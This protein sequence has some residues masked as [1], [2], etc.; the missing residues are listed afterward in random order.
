MGNYLHRFSTDTEFNAAYSGSEYHAPWASYTEES[1]RV[2]YNKSKYYEP[3][4]IIFE[5]S[6]TFYFESPGSEIV[7]LVIYKLNDDDWSETPSSS[8]N[9][10]VN[11][12][13]T[14]Q[15]KA[16]DVIRGWGAPISFML[17]NEPKRFSVRGNIMSV[18]YGE[19][20]ET[21]KNFIIGSDNNQYVTCLGFFSRSESYGLTNAGDL[22]LPV[23]TLVPECYIGM[24]SGCYSLTRGPKILP[25]LVLADA[26]YCDM[27]VECS[28]LV[29][30][31]ELPAPVLTDYCYNSMFYGCSS[32]N[33][34]K[35]LATDLTAY[36]A[37]EGWLSGTSSTGTFVKDANTTWPTGDSGIPTGWTVQNA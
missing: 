7:N 34:V 28:S 14:V 22:L 31:P 33:S 6:G 8:I 18:L 27:F 5:E 15:I 36:V 2:D 16:T 13:D 17:E 9:L 32:L 30:A 4:T 19:G 29:E 26:C 23:T 35:C 25:A 10:T 21:A 11:S 37:T 1:E 24:F 3:F 12:G 20:F